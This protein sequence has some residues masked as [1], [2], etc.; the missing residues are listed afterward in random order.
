MGRRQVAVAILDE[1]QK[2]DQEIVP[3]RPIA[4]QRPHL[5]A[6]GGLHLP[7]LGRCARRTAAAARVIQP[8]DCDGASG[9]LA[10][11]VIV[12]KRN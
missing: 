7:P 1:V 4:E 3:S 6:C 10:T 5:G 8:D 12:R 11:R 9:H 2:F